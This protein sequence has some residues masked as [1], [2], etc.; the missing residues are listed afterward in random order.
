MKE[1]KAKNLKIR[2]DMR[3]TVSGE[4]FQVTDVTWDG[5]DGFDKDGNDRLLSTAETR[6]ARLWN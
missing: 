4:F 2:R 3:L 1:N 6:E 5:V